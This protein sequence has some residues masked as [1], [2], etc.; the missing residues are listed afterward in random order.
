[1]GIERI[2]EKYKG[3]MARGLS[4]MDEGVFTY[5]RRV[6]HIVSIPGF[7]A[8]RGDERWQQCLG[9]LADLLVQ[10]NSSINTSEGDVTVHRSGN[11]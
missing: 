2:P 8:A 11:C 1:M 6:A 9:I 7:V 10:A 4:R 3:S 5:I